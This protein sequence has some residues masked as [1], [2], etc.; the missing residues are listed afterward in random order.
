MPSVPRDK[1]EA[2]GRLIFTIA[3]FIAEKGMVSIFQN[4]INEQ[5]LELVREMKAKQALESALTTAELQAIHAQIN[6][7]FVFNTLNTISRQ[8]ILEDA[9]KTQEMVYAMAEL[10]RVSYKKIDRVVTLEEEIK[11]I[12]DYLLIKQTRLH[13]TIEVNI[14]IEPECLNLEIP[15]FSIQPLLENALIHGLEPREEGGAVTISAVR[16]A[17]RVRL[18][19]EDNGLGMPTCTLDKILQLQTKFSGDNNITGIGISSVI[20]RLR[21]QH[22]DR[23]EWELQSRPGQGTTITLYI[24][25]D[26][27]W[28]TS[29]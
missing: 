9:P 19:V 12:H 25:Y 3:N 23:F 8:A 26:K 22:D 2:A 13:D 18:Q 28:E 29:A 4:K 20:K 27:G 21:Y 6:P 5:N 15:I 7:H 10:L 11:Y 17:G 1:F 14:Q 24:P 16:Q